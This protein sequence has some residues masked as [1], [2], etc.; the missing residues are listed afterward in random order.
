MGLPVEQI[1]TKDAL[2][3]LNQRVWQQSNS[4]PNQLGE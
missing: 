2:M 3:Q 4:F 1:T